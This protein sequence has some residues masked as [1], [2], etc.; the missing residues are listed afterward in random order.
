MKEFALLFTEN[1]FIQAT[2]SKN[3]RQ[4]PI[5]SYEVIHQTLSVWKGVRGSTLEG[6]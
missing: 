4:V 5:V 2:S 3:I 1:V 6:F